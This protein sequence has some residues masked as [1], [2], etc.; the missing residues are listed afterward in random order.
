MLCE[1]R[2]AAWVLGR[3]Q[4]GEALPIRAADLKCPL[5]LS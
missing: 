5:T 4:I 1:L 2:R 3:P